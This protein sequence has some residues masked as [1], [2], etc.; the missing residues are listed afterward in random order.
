MRDAKTGERMKARCGVLS[1]M[2]E[3]TR[4]HRHRRVFFQTKK[5]PK[6]E[7]NTWPLCTD[8]KHKKSFDPDRGLYAQKQ[9]W[10]LKN[11][12]KHKEVFPKISFELTNN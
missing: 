11:E 7:N 3:P 4:G 6:L 8:S 1:R 2:C 12:K 5:R 10:T 9:L